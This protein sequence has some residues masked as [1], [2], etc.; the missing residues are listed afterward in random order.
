MYKVSQHNLWDN[1]RKLR[2]DG[3]LDNEEEDIDNKQ[4]K[5]PGRPGQGHGGSNY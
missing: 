5:Y 2:T 4:N 1:R 3:N